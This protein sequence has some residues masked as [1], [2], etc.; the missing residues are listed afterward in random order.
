M[1]RMSNKDQ[2]ETLE[3]AWKKFYKRDFEAAL[4]LFE[5]IMEESETPE[6][7]FGRACALFRSEEYEEAR[8]AINNLIKSDMK[9]TKY[10]HTRAML[11]G[12]EEKTKEAIKDLERVVS[13]VPDHVEAWCDLGGAYMLNKD[14]IRAN[15]CFDKCIDL[16]KSYPD[17]WLGKGLVALEK[18]EFK[19]A[20]EF[21]N[22]AIKID[23]KNL[24]ALLARAEANFS[25]S[26]KQEAQGDIRKI[27]SL[28]PDIFREDAAE[29][30]RLNNDLDDDDN[31]DEDTDYEAYKLEE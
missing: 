11:S 7:L 15:D 1:T 13:L 8:K 10:L 19:R 30:G 29:N 17:A 2:S 3:K 25:S 23:G 28:N 14:Y 21:L 6:V 9:N 20:I 27:L 26:Q 16:D 12:A 22:V 31:V 5:E 4:S 24:T 18:K